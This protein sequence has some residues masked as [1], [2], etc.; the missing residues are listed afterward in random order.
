M[1]GFKSAS[2]DFVKCVPS[3]YAVLCQFLEKFYVLKR[4]YNY[5]LAER[6]I[7]ILIQ[8]LC[9]TPKKMSRICTFHM[10]GGGGL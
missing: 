1:R 7:M 9:P 3:S 4:M 5:F 10:G 8:R 2:C 6:I